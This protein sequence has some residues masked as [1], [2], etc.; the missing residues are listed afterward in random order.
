MKAV[1]LAGGR[2]ERLSPITDTRPKPLVPILARPVMDYTLSLLAHHGFDQAYVT[3]HY[4]PEQIRARYGAEAFGMAIEYAEETTPLGTCGGVK[5]LEREFAGEREILIIAGDAVCDFDLTETLRFHREKNADVTVVLSGV[6]TPLEYGV[7][8][9]D[10]AGR[11]TGFSEKP[12]WS[13]TLSEWVNTG[14]YVLSPRVLR[15]VPENTPFDFAR[16]LFP[17]LLRRGYALYG[18]KAEGYWCDVGE[19]SSFYRCNRDLIAGRA[20]T[21]FPLDGEEVYTAAGTNF[22]SS[23]ARLSDDGALTGDNVLSPGAAV[24]RGARLSGAVVMENVTVGENAV[25]K[26]AVL[27]ED[28]LVGAGSMIA[29][30]AVIGAGSVIEPNA[31]VP[32]KSVLAPRSRVAARAPFEGEKLLFTEIGS[33]FGRTGLDGAG[34]VELARRAAHIFK[35]KI[36]VLARGGDRDASLAA[37]LFENAL[38][39]EG[40]SVLSFGEGPREMA[41]F[42]AGEMSCPAFFAE[43]HGGRSYFFGF[44]PDSLPFLRATAASLS[45]PLRAAAEEKKEGFV[46]RLADGQERYIAY[47]AKLIGR[48][49]GAICVEGES[50]QAKFLRRAASRAGLEEKEGALVRI[51]FG[52]D[53][54]SVFAGGAALDAERSRAFL[55][56]SDR[57]RGR[58]RFAVPEKENPLLQKLLK[59]SG[60]E[61]VPFSL[62]Y[63]SKDE[64]A[65]RAFAARTARFFWDRAALAAEV[66]AR[67]DPARPEETARRF[68]KVPAWHRATLNY[69][70]REE[71]RAALIPAALAMEDDLVRVLPGAFAIRILSEAW[72]AEAAEDRMNEIRGK[73]NEIE[74]N[75]GRAQ[76][77]ARKKT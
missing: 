77:A 44:E 75:R 37:A 49:E 23:G 28:V 20:R 66:L 39:S 33:V 51:R 61:I 40:A 7:V 52:G 76:R 47:L 6:E 34:T 72:S 56:L 21:Y 59:E 57:E 29:P 62:S 1:V 58:R 63:T 31:A 46:W 4:R 24:A 13:E 11:V 36:G 68:E 64:A 65:S 14:V 5:A 10:G 71:D 27:C 2:G 16:D 67:I 53:G 48:K 32:E 45:R 73:L 69:L 19:L 42:L 22:V 41:S 30:D 9:L 50:D 8:P 12:D 55:L 25:V 26:D 17:L 15:E 60:C 43:S 70:P 3:V 74:K 54:F 38:V 35:G 18:Y